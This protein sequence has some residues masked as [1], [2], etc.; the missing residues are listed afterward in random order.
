MSRPFI[1]SEQ[2]TDSAPTVA[3]AL[4]EH[5]EDR[6]ALLA[7]LT[8]SWQSDTRIRATLLWGSFGRGEADDLSDLDPWLL[9]ADEAAPFIEPVLRQY[10]EQIGGLI[11]GT[12]NTPEYAPSGGGYISF[13]YE[14][15][16]GL[17]QVDCYWQP[18][19]TALPEAEYEVLFE[20]QAEAYINQDYPE[21]D[22]PEEAQS[23]QAEVAHGL[24]FAWFMF[25]IAAKYLA[26]YP[27]SDMGLMFYPKP[28][29]EEAAT[30]LGQVDLLTPEDWAVPEKPLEKADRLRHLVGKTEQL[31]VIANAQGCTLSPLYTSCLQRYLDM[32]EGILK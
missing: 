25:S 22:Y 5:R 4:R 18:A 17:L 31:R 21:Q 19:S 15:R 26:R 27:N 28:G 9:V 13:L 23:S 32:V 24:H 3:E 14:G 20:R 1:L 11:F 12:E 6:T 8:A 16:H 29:L 10:A 2:F 30:Q 7:S